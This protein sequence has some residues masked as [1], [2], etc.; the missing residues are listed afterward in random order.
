MTF[1]SDTLITLE[2]LGFLGAGF[3]LGVL[4]AL[5]LARF[6]MLLISGRL[7]ELSN[8]A[9]YENSMKFMDLARD[10]FGGFVREARQDFRARGDE[11]RQA[12]DPVHKVLDRYEQR[13]GMM[14]KERDQAYGSI[15][16]HL[17][18]MARTQHLLHTETGNLVKALRVPHVRGRW[19]EITLK[20]AAE[21]SGMAEHCDFSEQM[22]AGS[23]KGSLRP[24][25]VVTLPG[26]RRIIVDAK[27]PL[28]AYLDA[29]EAEDE[30]EREV[31]MTAHARQVL[32][33]IAQLGS[34][35]Y[36][37]RFSPSPEFVVLFIPG[38]NF[39]SAALAQKPDLIE[40]GIEQGVILA[41]PTT[42]IALLKAVAYSWQQQKGYENAEAI[43]DLGTQLYRRLST[44]ADHM[45]RLGS[46]I[47]R[48]AA[49]F[50][51]AAGAME[52][53]VMASARKLDDMAV[54]GKP[55]PGIKG[56]P[57]EKAKTRELKRMD[58]SELNTP[59]RNASE[60]Q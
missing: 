51:R 12:V 18:D 38:E 32:A 34:K 3:L 22:T 42:L 47:E 17:A 31:R 13:L 9:L 10:H 2:N 43:R 4:V 30:N 21:L 48:T 45:N 50:N 15:S 20:K 59:E 58:T 23:G 8:Q 25:M 1:F 11:I 19:G 27:V 26:N 36:T 7:K 29:L 39:F 44:M 41:T 57:V 56:V 5:I 40:K 52:T 14:E 54:T 37:E 60:S 55:L 24:D 35:K 53:R 28:I 46:D 6:G 49:T 33:H 16:R